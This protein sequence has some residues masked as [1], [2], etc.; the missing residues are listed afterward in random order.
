[1]NLKGMKRIN[2]LNIKAR[3]PLQTHTLSS[4]S[5]QERNAL[6]MVEG[7]DHIE[8]QCLWEATNIIHM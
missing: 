3:T 4:I 6:L 2:R 7:E 5:A 1:M 8:T